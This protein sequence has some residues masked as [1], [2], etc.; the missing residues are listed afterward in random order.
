MK[1]LTMDYVTI[2]EVPCGSATHRIGIDKRLRPHV[3]DHNEEMVEAFSA[4]GATRP[5]CVDAYDK[6]AAK[7]PSPYGTSLGYTPHHTVETALERSFTTAA[8]KQ[9]NKERFGRA[10]IASDLPR[11]EKVRLAIRYAGPSSRALM[12]FSEPLLGMQRRVALMKTERIPPVLAGIFALVAEDIPRKDRLAIAWKGTGKLRGWI[13]NSPHDLTSADRIK[14]AKS[15]PQDQQCWI[16]RKAGGWLPSRLRLEFAKGC[17][18]S[19]IILDFIVNENLLEANEVYALGW[20]WLEP[21]AVWYPSKG[22]APRDWDAA[23]KLI[24]MKKANLDPTDRF[25]L[26]VAAPTFEPHGR[27]SVA[28]SLYRRRR[29]LGFDAEQAAQLKKMGGL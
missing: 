24:L 17:R 29:Q 16:A 26:A 20:W 18:S 3:L 21:R 28:A 10:L 7:I 19:D 8:S 6:L 4:F 25:A 11:K 5:E 22:S 15:A 2:I 27:R 23:R 14:L 9:T 1:E 12:A 13:S